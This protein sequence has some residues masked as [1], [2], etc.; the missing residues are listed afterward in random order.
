MLKDSL[1]SFSICTMYITV[2]VVNSF[3][4]LHWIEFTKLH[5]LFP[6][7]VATE[8]TENISGSK[9][10]T[11]IFVFPY[12]MVCIKY[13]WYTYLLMYIAYLIAFHSWK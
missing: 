3:I 8:L 2:W 7:S 11:T 5:L 9:Y 1:L 4:K 6:L 10:Y 12:S 13:I